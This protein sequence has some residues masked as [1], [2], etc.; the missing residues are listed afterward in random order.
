LQ[1]KWSC[2]RAEGHEVVE[3]F[4]EEVRM[5]VVKLG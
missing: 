1:I 3:M 2:E 5:E 4:R